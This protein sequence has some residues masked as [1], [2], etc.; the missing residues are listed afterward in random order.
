MR[1]LVT[2]D[3]VLTRSFAF[4]SGLFSAPWGTLEDLSG[5]RFGGC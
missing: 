2:G 5:E 1:T 4:D 3:L